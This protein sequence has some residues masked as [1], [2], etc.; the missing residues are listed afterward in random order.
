MPLGNTG[1]FQTQ[2]LDNIPFGMPFTSRRELP[3]PKV[4]AQIPVASDNSFTDLPIPHPVSRPL[5]ARPSPVP[6]QYEQQNLPN[7]PVPYP[8]ERPVPYPVRRQSKEEQIIPPPMEF[9]LPKPCTMERCVPVPINGPIQFGQPM[10]Q[11]IDVP[12]ERCV[13][14]RETITIERPIPS[15]EEMGAKEMLPVAMSTETSIMF[16]PVPILETIPLPPILELDQ[17]PIFVDEDGNIDLTGESFQKFTEEEKKQASPAK[18]HGRLHR[19]FHRRN[20]S[21]FTTTPV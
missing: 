4:E 14:T 18:K 2:S 6:S 13:I 1:A 21:Q 15:F 20:K 9:D 5:L 10:E 16:D 19:L 8:G 17:R 12:M 3:T 11:K 7:A